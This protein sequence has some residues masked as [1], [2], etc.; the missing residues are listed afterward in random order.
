MEDLVGKILGSIGILVVPSEK[1]L[2]KRFSYPSEVQLSVSIY[3]TGVW[4]RD[5]EVTVRLTSRVNL[6][7]RQPEL[8]QMFSPLAPFK[9]VGIFY[10]PQELSAEVFSAGMN[11]LSADFRTGKQPP[12]GCVSFSTHKQHP[13][14]ESD[15]D[16]LPENWVYVR[17]PDSEDFKGQLMGLGADLQQLIGF[18]T[19]KEAEA[20]QKINEAIWSGKVPLENLEGY[21]M[22]RAAFFPKYRFLPATEASK[23][24]AE[25]KQ[26]LRGTLTVGEK[27]LTPKSDFAYKTDLNT[28]EAKEREA[29]RIADIFGFF[30]QIPSVKINNYGFLVATHEN[31]N[32]LPSAGRTSYVRPGSRSG[33][34]W[35]VNRS[36]GPRDLSARDAEIVF[37]PIS[38]NDSQQY[39][40]VANQLL[41]AYG[42]DFK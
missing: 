15:V 25:G 19:L 23:L 14:V 3:A 10:A 17:A 32:S 5:K 27:V 39:R 29:S 12:L 22:R 11:S 41:A 9:E 33:L 40:Q 24:L 8:K 26:G 36:G 18:Q 21:C 38:T 34:I 13:L 7:Q 37:A 28:R 20:V 31:T 16:E 1:K 30:K 35:C 2:E 6:F 42:V 4:K